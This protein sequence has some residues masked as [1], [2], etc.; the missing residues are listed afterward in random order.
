MPS[1][2]SIIKNTIK[3]RGQLVPWTQTSLENLTFNISTYYVRG[4]TSKLGGKMYDVEGLPLIKFL[5]K[6]KGMRTNGSI[7]ANTS[8]CRIFIKIIND[9]FGIHIDG[10][11]FGIIQSDGTILNAAKELI[12][13]AVHPPKM[14]VIAA[15]IK[16]R[17]GDTSY[18]IDI[19]GRRIATVK[20]CPT[21]SNWSLITVNE[22]A[23]GENILTLHTELSREEELWLLAFCIIEVVYHGHW[24]IGDNPEF[25]GD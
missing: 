6:A 7:E 17:F 18:P 20:V 10:K 22:N 23:A 1:L 25:T 4:F 8:N 13:T 14:S 24:I 16:Y 11:P 9:E 5:R 19:N 12:G 3:Y 15:E 21:Y 2:F